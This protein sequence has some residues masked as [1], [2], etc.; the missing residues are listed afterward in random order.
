ML[1]GEQV[2]GSWWRAF[3]PAPKASAPAPRGWEAGRQS[4]EVL[5]IRTCLCAR[6]P[7]LNLL[8]GD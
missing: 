5:S 7:P 3:A 4:W 8:H 6:L 1:T 2:A